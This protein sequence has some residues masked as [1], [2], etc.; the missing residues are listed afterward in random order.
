MELSTDNL[1]IQISPEC[2]NGIRS[3]P[4]CVNNGECIAYEKLKDFIQYGRT[5]E[6]SLHQDRM[7]KIINDANKTGCPNIGVLRSF[8]L[9]KFSNGNNGT[10]SRM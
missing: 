3:M 8:F 6:P 9:N 7:E 2:N 5:G 1:N 4:L 10:K